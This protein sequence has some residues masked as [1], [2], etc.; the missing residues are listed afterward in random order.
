MT[1]ASI[2]ALRPA[3]APDY[4]ATAAVFDRMAEE[5][6]SH[7]QRLIDLHQARFGAR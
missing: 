4:P 7:R 2:A 1:P 6:D 3:C 5:E